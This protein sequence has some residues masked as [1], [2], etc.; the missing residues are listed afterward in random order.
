MLS[1]VESCLKDLLSSLKCS[2]NMIISV[3]EGHLYK[4]TPHLALS[5]GMRPVDRFL[6]AGG[7]ASYKGQ[8]GPYGAYLGIDSLSLWYYSADNDLHNFAYRMSRG[9]VRVE[10]AW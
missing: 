3:N 9:I 4:D 1:A 2:Q 5:P 8:L 10:W 7:G 6:R